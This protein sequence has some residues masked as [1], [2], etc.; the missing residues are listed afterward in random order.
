[1]VTFR[2]VHLGGY[3]GVIHSSQLLTSK[4]PCL[5]KIKGGILGGGTQETIS[6][7]AKTE[8]QYRI[9]HKCLH[10]SI[11]VHSNYV[12]ETGHYIAVYS[13]T[14]QCYSTRVHF[15]GLVPSNLQQCLL[16]RTAVCLI[17]SFQHKFILFPGWRLL[18]FL[19][20]CCGG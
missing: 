8:E 10:Y 4:T 17:I 1:M 12:T 11:D 15:F 9:V 16:L 5:H 13:T 7:Y 2:W 14:V 18:K 19:L 20:L 3:I 6:F